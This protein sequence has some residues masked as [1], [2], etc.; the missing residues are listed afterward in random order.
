MRDPR[1]KEGP[2]YSTS[3]PR[4]ALGFREGTGRRATVHK[5]SREDQGVGSA[6]CHVPGGNVGAQ[7]AGVR[8]KEVS[9]CP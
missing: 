6:V 7:G 9:R 3:I 4:E 5:T 8:W 1:P 2:G